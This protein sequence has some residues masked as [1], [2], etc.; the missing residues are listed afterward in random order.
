MDNQ[1]AI[2][3]QISQSFLLNVR[4]TFSPSPTMKRRAWPLLLGFG[5]IFLIYCLGGLKISHVLIGSLCVLDAYNE[6]SRLFLKYFLPFILT[7]VTF[8]SM[9]YY[10]W[11]GVEG[12][13]H[14]REP[15]ELEKLLFGI[16]DNGV[17][18]S[19]NEYFEFRTWPIA[20]FFCG[21]AYL[22]FVAEYLTAAIYLLL[23]SKL[24]DLKFFGWCFYTVNVLGF[25]T[26]FIYP[27]A[28]PWYIT[29]FGFIPS[30]DARPDP[31]A[32]VRFDQLLG[33]H[34]FTAM[35]GQGIDVY[36]SIP[37]LHVSYPFLV[38]WVAWKHK[39]VLFLPALAFY[40]LMC[41]AAVYLQHHFVIDV[42]LGTA[43][44]ALAMYLVDT[45]LK[46]KESSV[47]TA[48]PEKSKLVPKL[49]A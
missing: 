42:V 21:L 47:D 7:G 2:D 20:D 5:Y 45:Y 27:A 6:K 39:R 15:Y 22:V 29:K 1:S 44:A 31:A 19:P 26:Y 8:D 14:V 28:P 35:Y 10:Y 36:G 33:T 25:A 3:Q 23:S 13:I 37:S 9:R 49:S 16:W 48:A 18:V 12:H 30:M 38:C 40:F 32:T 34:F 41:F 43:Y 46:S 17:K 4:K 24:K 11:A